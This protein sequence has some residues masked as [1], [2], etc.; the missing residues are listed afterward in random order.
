MI[1]WGSAQPIEDAPKDRRILVYVPD[2]DDNPTTSGWFSAQWTETGWQSGFAD[3]VD[4]RATL[5]QPSYWRELPDIPGG[6]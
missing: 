2:R 1:R 4:E 6:A 5:K 3:Y